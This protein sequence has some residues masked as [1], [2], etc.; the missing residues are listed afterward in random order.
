MR[1]EGADTKTSAT[2]RSYS[3][4]PLLIT[5]IEKS[6]AAAAAAAST[7]NFL[8]EES[9]R[10]RNRE[11]SE[12]KKENRAFKSAKN[13]EAAVPTTTL[14]PLSKRRDGRARVEWVCEPSIPH[15]RKT[16]VIFRRVSPARLTERQTG[17]LACG[18][19]IFIYRLLRPFLIFF[20]N[21]PPGDF[22]RGRKFHEQKRDFILE[23]RT[24]IEITV[25]FHVC[26]IS[27]NI[28]IIKAKALERKEYVFFK[29]TNLQYSNTESA[30]FSISGDIV[31][32]RLNH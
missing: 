21:W 17:A 11:S 12:R 31:D 28:F 8:V 18:R 7:G 20:C 14:A 25:I 30:R 32:V 24:I 9:T 22:T 13:F 19:E 16:F 26:F 1:G 3:L 5:R 27:Q 10:E 4:D 6:A 23:Y 15:A 2:T 29:H